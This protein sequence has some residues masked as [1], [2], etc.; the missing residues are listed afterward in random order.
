M[1][2]LSELAAVVSD[3]AH[4]NPDAKIVRNDVGNIAF[5]TEDGEPLGWV[6]LIEPSWA[7]FEWDPA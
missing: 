6:D 3:V 1:T 2:T 5:L 7:Y 4:H